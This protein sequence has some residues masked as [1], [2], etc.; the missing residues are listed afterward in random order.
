M[1]F[2]SNCSCFP[3][4]IRAARNSA[5]KTLMSKGIV[6]KGDG[7]DVDHKRPISKGGSNSLAN[8]FA[9]P[10]S[11]NRSFARNKNSSIRSQRSKRER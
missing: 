2:R 10:K 11:T 9:V 6:K 1:L 3:V 4:T 8:L 5:R 7:K